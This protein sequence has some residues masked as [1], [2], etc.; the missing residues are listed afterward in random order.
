M[1]FLQEYQAGNIVDSLK[2]TLALK[3]NVIR[4]GETIEVGA[5]QIVPGDIVLVDDVS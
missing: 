5:E 2:Q 4:N 1:G 3:A